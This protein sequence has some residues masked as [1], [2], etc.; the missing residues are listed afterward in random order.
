MKK[1]YPHPH[2]SLLLLA[3]WLLVNNTISPG[4]ILL[5]G[6]LATIIPIATTAFGPEP[7]LLQR[8]GILLKYTG[9]LIVDIFTANL[10]VALWIIQPSRRLQPAFLKYELTLESPL[11][12]SV[13]ANTISLTPGTV[14]RDLSA[15]QRYLLIHCLHSTDKDGLMKQIRQRYEEPLKEAF[16]SC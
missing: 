6:F 14:S 7:M 4:H 13:L 16:R 11:A 5:G 3:I 12:I 10:Q 1:L 9:R 8:P 2:L 15:D